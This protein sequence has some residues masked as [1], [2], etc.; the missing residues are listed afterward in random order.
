MLLVVV[1][2]ALRFAGITADSLWLDEGYQSMVG[3]FGR[4]MPDLQAMPDAPYRF[5]FGEAGSVQDVLTNFRQVDPLC[6]PLYAVL[7]NQWMHLFG[8]SDLAVRSLSTVISALSLSA[9]F[10]FANKFLGWRAAIFAGIIQAVSPFDIHYAQEARM[11]SLIE[12]MAVLSSGFLLM[13]LL[14]RQQLWQ[15]VLLVFGYGASTWALINSHYT[16]LFVVAFQVAVSLATIAALR[17]F[18]LGVSV[19]GG[20]FIAKLLWMPWLPMFFQSAK[21]RTASFYVSREP[22]LWWPFFALLVKIPGNWAIFMIGNKVVAYAVPAFVTSFIFLFFALLAVLPMQISAGWLRKLRLSR[23]VVPFSRR[24][25]LALA[26]VWLWALLPALALWL[27]DVIENHRVVEISR[28]LMGTAP[29]VFILAGAGLAFLGLNRRVVAI[30]LAV[31]VFFAVVAN[32]YNH[33]VP[34]REPWREMAQLVKDN[35]P[36]DELILVAQYYDIVC[37]DRYLDK[38][39]R[40]VGISP[41]LGQDYIVKLIADKPTFALI[42]AQEGEAAHTLIPARWKVMR[43]LDLHHGLHLRMYAE[44]A[45]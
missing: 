10:F 44:E 16:G 25:K 27:I 11:Y 7:L 12:L 35:V 13:I 17:D 21:L 9:V 37:L 34:Q 26:Y 4:K 24:Q 40:K 8:Y 33:Y 1:A 30:L 18:K 23:A 36:D 31:H 28:Y 22:S 41:A 3:A 39:Y 15:R 32:V 45:K 19:A 5:S 14:K 38:P 29:A 42:T 43:K 2:L 6:P 20:W